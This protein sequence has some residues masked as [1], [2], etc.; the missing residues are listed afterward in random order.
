MNCKKIDSHGGEY[1]LKIHTTGSDET[2]EP[3]NNLDL[4]WII[5]KEWRMNSKRTIQD[6]TFKPLNHLRD[7]ERECLISKSQTFQNGEKVQEWERLE[8]K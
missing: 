7:R 6:W 3:K 8:F 5:T 4:S 1:R 2:N